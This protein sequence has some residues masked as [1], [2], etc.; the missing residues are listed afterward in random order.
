MLA[1]ILRTEKNLP[2]TSKFIPSQVSP[3][4]EQRVQNKGFCRTESSER[5]WAKG[6][7]LM[8]TSKNHLRELE[9]Y[10]AEACPLLTTIVLFYYI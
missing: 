2:N 1:R 3:S 7:S 9:V 6:V 10:V 4:A 8:Y 5:F